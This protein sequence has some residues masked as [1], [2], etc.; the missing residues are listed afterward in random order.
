MV[1]NEALAGEKSALRST[2]LP[3]WIRQFG[4]VQ[5]LRPVILGREQLYTLQRLMLGVF[6]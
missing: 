3:W 6:H 4:R 1:A 5:G 2:E